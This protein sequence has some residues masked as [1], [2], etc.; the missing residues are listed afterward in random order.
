MIPILRRTALLAGAAA[1]LVAVAP[2]QAQTKLKWAHVYETSEPYHTE[3]VWAAE[4]IKKRSNGKFDIKVFPASSLGKETDINQGMTLGTVDMIISGFYDTPKRRPMFDF[5]DYLKAGAQF[6]TLESLKEIQQ[7]TDLCGKTI[8][9]TRGTSY[10]DTVKVWSEKNCVGAGKEPITV[11][12][13]TDL[14]QQV[15]NLKQGR[16]VAANEPTPWI[17]LTERICIGAFLVWVVVLA[18]ALR[19]GLSPSSD[20]RRSRRLEQS[21]A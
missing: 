14:G 3:S 13:D 17:G 19:A 12:V 20:P 6:Y 18:L 5:I 1:A 16:A 9:T 10:P 7:L 11:I 8:T 15:A 21:P 4:E 2:A